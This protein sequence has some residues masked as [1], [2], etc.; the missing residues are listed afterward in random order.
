MENTTEEKTEIIEEKIKEIDFAERKRRAI[1]EKAEDMLKAW[2]PKTLIGK[3]VK[4]GKINSIDEILGKHKILEPEIVDYL[5]K[6]KTDL[7][8]IGQRKG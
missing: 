4:E 8:N 2:V 1:E 5:L 6:L 3:K 7:L